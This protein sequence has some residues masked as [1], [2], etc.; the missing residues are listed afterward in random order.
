MT[1]PANEIQP[2]INTPVPPERNSVFVARVIEA[3]RQPV[4]LL[5][6]CY[7]SL[8]W[9]VSCCGNDTNG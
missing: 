7:G 5:L 6:N 8:A 4:Y 2:D 3:C 9:S 1:P